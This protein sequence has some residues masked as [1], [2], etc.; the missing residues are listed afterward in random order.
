MPQGAQTLKTGRQVDR[1]QGKQNYKVEQNNDI[2]YGYHGK[3]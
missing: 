1:S 3:N 2:H